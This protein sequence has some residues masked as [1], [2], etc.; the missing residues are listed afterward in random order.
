MD[1]QKHKIG[2]QVLELTIPDR[3]QALSIQNSASNLIKYKLNPALDKLFSGLTTTDD[4]FIIDRLVLDLGDVS[5]DKFN[6]FFPTF[7]FKRSSSYWM[8]SESISIKFHDLFWNNRTI[9]HS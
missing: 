8:A 6:V 2:R 1:E 4:V 7:K 3:D 9:F 5:E